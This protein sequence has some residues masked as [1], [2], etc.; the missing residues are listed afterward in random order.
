MKAASIITTHPL[1][2]ARQRVISRNLYGKQQPKWAAPLRVVAVRCFP[3]TAVMI[4]PKSG[5]LSAS[6]HRPETLLVIITSTSKRMC[7]DQS[8]VIIGFG[9][10]VSLLLRFGY[11]P[12]EFASLRILRG[13][14]T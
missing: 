9:M 14:P 11:A 7:N 4:A 2:T 12:V 6:T 1:V 3:V 13:L 5:T 10:L 8:E